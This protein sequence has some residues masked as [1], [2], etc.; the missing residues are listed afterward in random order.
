M[1]C[2][3]PLLAVGTGQIL[4]S[5]QIIHAYMSVFDGRQPT[6]YLARIPLLA[7][8]VC[9]ERTHK[10][11]CLYGKGESWMTYCV[12]LYEQRTERRKRA[13]FA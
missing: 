13:G 11:P 5:V 3:Y 1:Q 7:M 2:S 8:D 12:D 10:R 4:V 6:I 9:N